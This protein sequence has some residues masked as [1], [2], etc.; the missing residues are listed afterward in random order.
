MGKKTT[1]KQIAKQLRGAGF[2]LPVI[3]GGL[4]AEWEPLPDEKKI[5]QRVITFLEDRRVLYTPY[6]FEDGNHCVQSVIEIRQFLTSVLEDLPNEMGLPQHLRVIRGACREFL[7]KVQARGRGHYPLYHG[8]P[9]AQDFFIALG[10]LRRTFGI[11]LG[12]LAVKYHLGLEGDLA[13]ILPAQT[14]DEGD[15]IHVE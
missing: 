9:E 6:P 7:D 14:E 10:E 3:G 12:C 2:E 4:S 5:A 1:W 13:T 15:Q 11:H 8:G